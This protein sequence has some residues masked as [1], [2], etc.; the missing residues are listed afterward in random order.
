[1]L[2]LAPLAN[3][4]QNGYAD[5]AKTLLQAHIA[6]SQSS[7]SA[8]RLSAASMKIYA[9]H[10]RQLKQHAC[11]RPMGAMEEGTRWSS[12]PFRWILFSWRDSK[13]TCLS[14]AKVYGHF[15]GGAGACTRLAVPQGS[16]VCYWHAALCFAQKQAARPVYRDRG[17]WSPLRSSR[18]HL[19]KSYTC[20]QQNDNFASNRESTHNG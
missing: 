18:G 4:V 20:L 9:H 13:L 19:F 15:A 5:S 2:L 16:S 10:D 12:D 8:T 14:R 3:S 7:A 6:T 11:C 1:M 17:L